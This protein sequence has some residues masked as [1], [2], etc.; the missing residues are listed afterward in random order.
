MVPPVINGVTLV[1][2]KAGSK[3]AV[4]AIAEKPE[5]NR[6]GGRGICDKLGK[7]EK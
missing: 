7:G 1:G 2:V 5:R 6:A 3:Q 4:T